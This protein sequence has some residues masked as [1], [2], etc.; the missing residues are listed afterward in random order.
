MLA[1]KESWL[2]RKGVR[3]EIIDACKK[4]KKCN[5]CDG[6]NGTV[7]KIQTASF[8]LVHEKY[9]DKAAGEMKKKLLNSLD[10][11]MEETD[12]EHESLINKAVDDLNPLVV[13]EVTL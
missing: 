12:G 11:F 13:L 2:D 10:R 9:K 6:H 1:R 4:I 3:K 5:Y 7:K 8:K